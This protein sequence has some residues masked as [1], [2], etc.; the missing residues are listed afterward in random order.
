MIRAGEGVIASNVSGNRDEDVFEDPDT[1]DMM[2]VAGKKAL[3]FGFGAHECVAEW[4]ARAEL[5]IVFGELGVTLSGPFKH[6]LHAHRRRCVRPVGEMGNANKFSI[7]GH[8]SS[9]SRRSGL[10]FRL[11]R[12]NT[13]PCTEMLESLSCL[14]FGNVKEKCIGGRLF[15]AN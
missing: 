10:P 3:G 6:P 12:S 2:R 4:L 9:D 7:Q 8:Y 15:H 11:R 1:F 13:V 14:L 5:E